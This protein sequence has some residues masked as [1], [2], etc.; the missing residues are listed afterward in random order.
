MPFNP[1]AQRH[2]S[3]NVLYNTV[4]D[5]KIMESTNNLRTNK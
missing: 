1:N 3:K 2:M 5:R 4:Y